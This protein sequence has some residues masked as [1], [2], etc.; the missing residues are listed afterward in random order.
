MQVAQVAQHGTCLL[1]H[2]RVKFGSPSAD[3]GRTPAYF[4]KRRA[5]A[6]RSLAAEKAA[7]A[8]AQ[9]FGLDVIF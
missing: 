1:R 4:S 6:D 8:N 3:C 5:A 9:H 7:A 2:P